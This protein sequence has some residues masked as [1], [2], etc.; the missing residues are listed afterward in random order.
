M[1][2][3]QTTELSLDELAATAV[4]LGRELEREA[5]A[6]TLGGDSREY[7][8]VTR[9]LRRL[10]DRDPFDPRDDFALAALEGII[11]A[12]LRSEVKGSEHRFFET[13]YDE[14]GQHGE[15]RDCPIYGERGEQLL[16]VQRTFKRFIKARAEA[17]DRIAGERAVI[18]LLK[19]G[20]S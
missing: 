1:K 3:K 13:H 7:G 18:R 19:I 15:V 6:V 20:C 4:R 14:F 12:D 9:T 5:Q 11:E 10:S 2:M 17:L 8:F 16:A